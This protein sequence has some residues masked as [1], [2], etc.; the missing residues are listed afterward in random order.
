MK[1]KP[2]PRQIM[3]IIDATEKAIWKNYKSYSR[4]FLYIK[5]WQEEIWD[6]GNTGWN[7]YNGFNFEIAYRNIDNKE[8]DLFQTLYNM[9]HDLLFKI[10]FDMEI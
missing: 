4:V 5:R 7:R 9:N 2:S 6:A 8:I 3:K 1:T 10:A